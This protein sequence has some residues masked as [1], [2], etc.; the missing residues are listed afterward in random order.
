MPAGRLQEL[1]QLTAGGREALGEHA[2]DDSTALRLT[3]IARTL[4]DLKENETVTAARVEEAARVAV[5]TKSNGR[6]R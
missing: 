6:T 2:R 4:A 5:A 3:R 1:S